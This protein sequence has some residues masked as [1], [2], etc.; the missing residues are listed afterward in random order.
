MQIKPPVPHNA[1]NL[2][3]HKCSPKCSD[4][5]VYEIVVAQNIQYERN[6]V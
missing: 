6:S 2:P 1:A 5:L 4:L 3:Y